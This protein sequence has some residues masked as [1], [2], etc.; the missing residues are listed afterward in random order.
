M[1]WKKQKKIDELNL[2]VTQLEELLC[3]LNSHNWVEVDWHLESL[4]GGYTTD[5]THH[6]SCSRCKKYVETTRSL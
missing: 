6:Y 1:F 4:D 5:V 3:P 2:R